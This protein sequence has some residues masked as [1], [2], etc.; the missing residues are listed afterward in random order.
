M[1]QER[2]GVT[3][4]NWYTWSNPQRFGKRTGR[5]ENGRMNRDHPNYSIVEI[6]QNTKKSP[7]N[8]KRLAVTQTPIE[9]HQ[10]RFKRKTR[11]KSN[12]KLT[13]KY[14]SWHD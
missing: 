8:L 13:Q 9:D 1:E 11:Y 12:D 2:N 6:D 3:I 4:Y 14:K 7:R 10:L 5:A